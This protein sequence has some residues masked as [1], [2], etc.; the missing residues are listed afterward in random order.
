MCTPLCA[1]YTMIVYTQNVVYTM[2]YIFNLTLL[3]KTKLKENEYRDVIAPH[4]CSCSCIRRKK[5]LHH[6]S[7]ICR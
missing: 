7:R 4:Q 5:I 1:C 3:K 2:I 6:Q